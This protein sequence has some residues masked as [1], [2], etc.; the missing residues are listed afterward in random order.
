MKPYGIYLP[1][2]RPA[3]REDQEVTVLGTCSDL[4]DVTAAVE[5]VGT[6]RTLEWLRERLAAT[7]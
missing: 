1:S 7:G 3:Y 6:P 5:T 2:V 4:G